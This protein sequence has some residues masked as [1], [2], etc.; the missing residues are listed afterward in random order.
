MDSPFRGSGPA[1]SPGVAFWCSY[2]WKLRFW[3]IL[4]LAMLWPV[5]K[6]IQSLMGWDPV[7]SWIASVPGSYL[8]LTL[9]FSIV[10]GIVVYTS[11]AIHGIWRA[12]QRE[13][14]RRAV[15]ERRRLRLLKES[16]RSAPPA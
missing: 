11:T 8:V 3:L 15:R 2:L 1:R 4:W 7:T 14:K 5:S 16:S 9:G 6:G 10:A 13:L 12:R